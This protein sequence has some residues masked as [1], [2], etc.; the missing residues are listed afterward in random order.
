M[1]LACRFHPAGSMDTLSVISGRWHHCVVI[2]NAPHRIARLHRVDRQSPDILL[3]SA[4]YQHAVQ[5]LFLCTQAPLQRQLTECRAGVAAVEG[6]LLLVDR[7]LVDLRRLRGVL[8]IDVDLLLCWREQDRALITDSTI[9][10]GRAQRRRT[11]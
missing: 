6:A 9:E 8:V 3:S 5:E 4:R 2:A 10:S 1:A 7:H 11:L